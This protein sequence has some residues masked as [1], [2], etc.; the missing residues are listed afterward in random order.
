MEGVHRESGE[1]GITQSFILVNLADNYLAN[2]N[3]ETADKIFDHA[4]EAA[5]NALNARAEK[6]S[7]F[8]I[9]APSPSGT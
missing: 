6:A 4:I 7:I 8:I 3:F 5:P 1:S 2:K 9:A